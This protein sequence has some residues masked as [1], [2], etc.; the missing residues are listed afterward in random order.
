MFG[1]GSRSGVWAGGAPSGQPTL[2]GASQ[3]NLCSPTF[4][5]VPVPI[6]EHALQPATEWL[7]QRRLHDGCG[8]GLPACASRM[9]YNNVFEQRCHRHARACS[10]CTTWK[11]SRSTRRSTR[12]AR[13]WPSGV[14]FNYN[15][16]YVLDLNYVNYADERF[17]S[18]VRSRLLLGRGKRDLLNPGDGPDEDDQQDARLRDRGVEPGWVRRCPPW[19]RSAMRRSRASART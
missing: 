2:G 10:G 18:A 1:T 6:A 17:R 3:G 19:Q 7:S 4:V 9:D 12:V 15:K 11:A 13:P 14:K 8:L 5:G 16:K